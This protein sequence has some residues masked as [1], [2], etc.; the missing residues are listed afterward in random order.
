MKDQEN[1]RIDYY[2]FTLS[3]YAFLGHRRFIE[4]C[5]KYDIEIDYH[6]VKVGTMYGNSGGTPISK[7][8]PSRLAY[9]LVAMRRWAEKLAIP[10]NL[11]PKHFPIDD[12]LSACLL[13]V[14]K[15]EKSPQ[16]EKVVRAIFDAVWLRDLDISDAKTLANILTG[17][18][19]DAAAILDKAQGLVSRLEQETL[20]AIDKGIF[21]TPSYVFDGEIFWGQDQLEFLEQAIERSLA[22]KIASQ[23]NKA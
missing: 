13:L 10:M 20:A 21:G 16:I 7:R 18:G 14:L 3:P 9:R 22:D 4:L 1:M 8:H 15:D 6:P 17:F 5:E 11:E 12:S 2:F 19:L 23:M